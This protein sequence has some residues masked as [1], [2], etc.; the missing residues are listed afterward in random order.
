MRY[1][2]LNI[3]HTIQTYLTE[4]VKQLLEASHKQRVGGSGEGGDR[5]HSNQ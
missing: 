4:A 5:S 2:K 3:D 1:T